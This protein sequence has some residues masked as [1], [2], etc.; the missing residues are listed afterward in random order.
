MSDT[1]NGSGVP[2]HLTCPICFEGYTGQVL[3][4]VEGHAM[5]RVCYIA[6]PPPKR[7][8]SCRVGMEQCIRNRIVESLAAERV[9]RC[10][11]KGC[12]H[13]GLWKDVE[14]D[15]SGECI[16]RPARCVMPGCIWIGYGGEDFDDHRRRSHGKLMFAHISSVFYVDQGISVNRDGAIILNC[17]GKFYALCWDMEIDRT[18]ELALVFRVFSMSHEKTGFTLTFGDDIT[19]ESVTTNS[20]CGRPLSVLSWEDSYSGRYIGA[21]IRLEIYPFVGTGIRV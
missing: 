15:H 14:R 5:C 9:V 10:K 11:W 8:P 16:H 19:V 21:N 13:V 20:S 1:T 6:L 3:Q 4:C 17:A 12:T 7:C 18:G 2:E